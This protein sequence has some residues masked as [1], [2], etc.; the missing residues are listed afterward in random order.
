MRIE[1]NE[2]GV[3]TIRPDTPTEAYALKKWCDES[4]DKDCSMVKLDKLVVYF[5][6]ELEGENG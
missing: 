5:K 4:I 6:L 3:L 2:I 1:M